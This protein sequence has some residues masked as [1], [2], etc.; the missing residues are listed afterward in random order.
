MQSVS[1]SILNHLATTK[2]EFF[3]S[4]KKEIIVSNK[5]VSESFVIPN[6]EM[7]YEVIQQSLMLPK[8]ELN[9]LI[10]DLANKI[11]KT[12]LEEKT[13]IGDFVYNVEAAKT[14]LYKMLHS[15]YPNWPHLPEVIESISYAFSYFLYYTVTVYTDKKNQII[16]EK[17]QYITSTHQ[18]RLTILGQMTSSFVH[19][20]RNPLTSILGFI[21]LLRAEQPNLPYL[22]IIENELDQLKFSI[23]QFL[24]LSKREIIEQEKIAF[25]FKELLEE[26]LSFL[27]PRILEVNVEIIKEIEMDYTFQGYK[28]EI[29]Q[30][31]VNIIFNAI[32]VLAEK[33]MPTIRIHLAEENG[34]IQ[35]QISNNGP[36]I[37]ESLLDNIFEPF[38]TTKKSGTGIG[39]FVCKEIIEKHRGTLTCQSDDQ[40]TN[41]TILLPLN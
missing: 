38:F 18:E 33:A 14:I 31:L 35:I 23:S 2:E 13:N 9:Y 24:L 26:V 7:F 37:P 8:K 5:G 28:D 1:E 15:S 10:Q 6:M 17:N 41:F 36:K 29:R 20:F 32:D 21:Q 34:F 4:W 16:E 12:K 40:W 3:S 22:D 27:Y 11:V 25:R 39:L 19:E 30:V